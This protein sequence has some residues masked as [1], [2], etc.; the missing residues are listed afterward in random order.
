D[1]PLDRIAV[2]G[3]GFRGYVMVDA[4]EGGLLLRIVGAPEVW[5]ARDAIRG[6]RRSSWTIDRA[7]EKDGLHLV[8]WTL[9]DRNVDSYLRMNEPAAFD[10]VTTRII[11][12]QA[13]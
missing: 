1:D 11:E 6:I 8:A 13:S 4:S 10:A 2:H 3:L 12:G 9:G 7:V 5:I